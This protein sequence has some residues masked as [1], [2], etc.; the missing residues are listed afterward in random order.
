MSL[1]RFTPDSRRED[2]LAH[3]TTMIAEGAHQLLANLQGADGGLV[4]N[5]MIGA[6]VTFAHEIGGSPEALQQAYRRI[7]DAIPSI[8]ATR[9]EYARLAALEAVNDDDDGPEAA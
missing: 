9:D 5:A 8:F 3:A 7:A 1:E 4:I 2:A 6:T